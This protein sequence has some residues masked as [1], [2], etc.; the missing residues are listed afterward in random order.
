MLRR[1]FLRLHCKVKL[2][3]SYR[4]HYKAA[5][6]LGPEIELGNKLKVNEGVTRLEVTLE[7]KLLGHSL[8]YITR[9]CYDL[10]QKLR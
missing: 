5:L 7:T 1:L 3:R 9:L 10:E 2:P 6:R 4:L 8:G